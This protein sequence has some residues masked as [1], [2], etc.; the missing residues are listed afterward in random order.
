MRK[1][2]KTTLAATVI[3]SS[4]LLSGCG[5]FSVEKKVDKID[6]PQNVSMDKSTDKEALEV[7]KNTDQKDAVT[8]SVKRD[9]FL[10]DKNGFVVPQ[11]VQL[12][13]DQAAARQVL[14]YLVIGGPVDEMLPNGF[15][16]VI[17]RDTE[18][19]VKLEGNK[20]VADFSKEFGTYAPEDEA[21]ILQSITWTLT[22]FENIESVELQVN[23]YKLE[24]MPVNQTP[25]AENLSRVDGI[26][27]DNS[28]VMDITNTRQVTLYFYV[29]NKDS[30]YY[31]PITKRI[32]NSEKD[33]IAAVVNALIKGPKLT[34]NLLNGISSD[35]ELLGTTYKDGLVTLDFNEAIF[36]SFDEKV[37][38]KQVM[39][40][41]VLSL[42]EQP[43]I[44]SVAITVDGDADITNKDGKKLSEPVTR[45]IN[46]NIGSF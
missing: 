36:G 2:T 37:I 15:R 4:V 46:I 1:V 34:S 22:Q 6:P 27:L 41:L 44:E 24:A 12:P 8:N 5:L 7:S 13:N 29:K 10:I 16:A 11:T 32:N 38:S 45:P 33:N 19:D 21:K 31:V 14:E 42:T 39:N 23:G 28:D 35:A 26:N 25:I 17:P 3:A 18:V 43:G 9:L 30:E 40:S 20:L